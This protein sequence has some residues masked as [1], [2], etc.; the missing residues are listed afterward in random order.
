MELLKACSDVNAGQAFSLADRIV[1]CI[2]LR[3]GR[4]G[5]R[6]LGRD[7]LDVLGAEFLDCLLVGEVLGD[8]DVELG[9]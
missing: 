1:D 3:V 2:D 5:G 8:D 9:G 7:D 4:R 6:Q